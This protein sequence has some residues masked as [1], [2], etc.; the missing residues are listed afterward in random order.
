MS[1]KF[2]TLWTPKGRYLPTWPCG[3][4]ATRVTRTSR[5][6]LKVRVSSDACLAFFAVCNMASLAGLSW[7]F[8]IFV[9]FQGCFGKLNGDDENPFRIKKLN[10][11]WKKAQNK[12]SERKLS[13]F[14]RFLE[15]QD[16]A[17]IR[18]KE[19][20]A[21]GGDEDGEMEAMLRRKFSCL[22]ERFGLDHLVDDGNEIKDNTAGHGDKRL[23]E[24]WESVQKE[25]L[26]TLQLLLLLVWSRMN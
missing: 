5:A 7:V 19:L 12:M 11:I 20:K 6:T 13:E 4:V 24:L 15:L 17:E 1:E 2:L 22:L 23:N 26:C 9:V 8:V 14:R 3:L 21:N 25:G 16:R 18:W 10:M